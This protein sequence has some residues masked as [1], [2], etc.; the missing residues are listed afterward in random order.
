M[1]DVPG[2]ETTE[3]AGKA[4]AMQRDAP[5]CRSGKRNST[6][7]AVG[8][9]VRRINIS[10]RDNDG[11]TPP[12]S[13]GRKHEDER[14]ALVFARRP[15]RPNTLPA[16]YRELS[17]YLP[18]RSGGDSVGDIALHSLISSDD[19]RIYKFAPS[20]RRRRARLAS[21]GKYRH[22]CMYYWSVVCKHF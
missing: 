14:R 22:S 20:R 19:W 5:V 9:K 10:R 4:G 18:S 7:S 8:A 11:Q 17:A 1:H 3:K 15:A 6:C 21:S 13:C 2:N 16:T 12:A